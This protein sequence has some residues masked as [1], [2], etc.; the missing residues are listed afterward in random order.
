MLY[1]VMSEDLLLAGEAEE[2][3]RRAEIARTALV[4]TGESA[5]VDMYD[6]DGN[7]HPGDEARSYDALVPIFFR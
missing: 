7:L 4:S 3:R 2:F 6:I 5:V 1:R